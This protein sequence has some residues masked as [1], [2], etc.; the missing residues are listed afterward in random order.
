MLYMEMSLN[1]LISRADDSVTWTQ[2]A[3]NSYFNACKE[4]GN[5][6]IGKRSFQTIPEEEAHNMSNQVVVVV[7]TTL[8][9]KSVPAFVRHVATTPIDALRWLH[10]EG[11]EKALIGGGS[12]LNGS[13]LAADLVGEVTVDIEPIMFASG[14]AF[15]SALPKD[16]SLTM[17]SMTRTG[18]N[19]L[20]V[21]YFVDG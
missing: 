12:T 6:V 18:P 5:L 9:P 8:D 2:P 14:K 17:R 3:W 7:S 20:Q 4:Y 1:G 19:S 11:F 16:I 21:R 10:A 15:C 13:F